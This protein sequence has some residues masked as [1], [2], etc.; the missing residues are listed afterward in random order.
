MKSVEQTMLTKWLEAEYEDVLLG[1][2]LS[3]LREE[4]KIAE[5]DIQYVL[6]SLP[7]YRK[8]S[9]V[10]E[11]FTREVKAKWTGK[12]FLLVL[13]NLT[14]NVDISFLM[15]VTE[16]IKII[17]TSRD[18]LNSIDDKNILNLQPFTESEARQYLMQ[19][20]YRQSSK[21]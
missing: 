5:Q 20:H 10:F 8:L 19:F 21:T 12:P 9:G 16:N 11:V 18:K 3:I 14:K 2:L 1:Q 15:Y 13:D 4:L 7:P 6:K 17:I